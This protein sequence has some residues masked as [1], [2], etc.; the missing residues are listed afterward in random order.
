MEEIKHVLDCIDAQKEYV[1]D[2]TN[3]S[4]PKFQSKR[5][6]IALL[7]AARIVITHL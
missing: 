2:V 4:I 3:K 1:T 6:E 7:Q 5:H